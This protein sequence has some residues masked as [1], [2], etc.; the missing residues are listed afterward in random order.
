MA[1]GKL[2]ALYNKDSDSVRVS[3]WIDAELTSGVVELWHGEVKIHTC[4][5][6]PKTQN[7][8][9]GTFS[10]MF[11]KPSRNIDL[12]ARANLVIAG[13]PI[14]VSSRVTPDDNA[15][16]LY[17]VPNDVTPIPVT[18]TEP[19]VEMV[20]ENLHTDSNTVVRKK[21]HVHSNRPSEPVVDNFGDPLMLLLAFGEKWPVKRGTGAINYT[22]GGNR[23]Y[24]DD[25]GALQIQA[26]DTTPIGFAFSE[27]NTNNLL[28]NVWLSL[29]QNA[30][31]GWYIEYDDGVGIDS[32]LVNEI[33]PMLKQWNI[34]LTKMVNNWE[35]AAKL[36]SY[37]TPISN[38]PI[39]F[40]ILASIRNEL[41]DL[42][43]IFTWL[44]GINTIIH[45]DTI[46]FD[47]VR[48]E[49][50]WGMLAHTITPA[51]GATHLSV[52]IM[53]TPT[54]NQTPLLKLIA[55]NIVQATQPTSLIIGASNRIQDA[56][57]MPTA[58][59]IN[60]DGSS[61]ELAAILGGNSTGTIFDCRDGFG[62]GVAALW[63]GVN[64]SFIINAGGGDDIIDVPWT[65]V[66][67]VT[68][69][70]IWRESYRAIVVNN[71]MLLENHAAIELP[72][73]VGTSLLVAQDLNC[74]LLSLKIERSTPT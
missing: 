46:A 33:H 45:E 37:P 19:L 7:L 14:S 70:F 21:D 52:V 36:T 29:T 18:R 72:T 48:F 34:Q 5:I 49:N 4:T 3:L 15:G 61:V 1:Q 16:E 31:N 9:D 65:P 67:N 44:N 30:P 26:Q 56:W 68:W 73:S 42:K 71:S 35:A 43:V 53:A 6:N 28:D 10:I 22:G 40:S 39:S 50:R 11:N 23:L 47:P 66:S 38:S 64:L 2:L 27:Q 20:E 13:T 57:R 51:A 17:E 25:V 69:K 54:M 12:S 58:L 74:Q 63:T 62:V 24:W 8:D 55:P 60:P 32:K 41:A 59:N